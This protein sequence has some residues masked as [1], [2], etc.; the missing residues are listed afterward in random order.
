MSEVRKRE[1]VNSPAL[2][3]LEQVYGTVRYEME[4]QGGIV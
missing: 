3:R 4:V 1:G 2:Y